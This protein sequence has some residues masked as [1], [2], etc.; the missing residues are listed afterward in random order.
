M[1]SKPMKAGGRRAEP[2]LSAGPGARMTAA[3]STPL[4]QRARAG[5]ELEAFNEWLA[6]A[7][8]ARRIVTLQE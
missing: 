3:Q 4:R 7:E 2:I 6:Q 1:A 8:A 5:Y